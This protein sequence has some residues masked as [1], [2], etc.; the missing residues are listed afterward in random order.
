MID[1]SELLRLFFSDEQYA[2]GVIKDI[3]IPLD[4]LKEP[5]Y[6]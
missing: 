1:E 5:D 3:S 2:D 6:P 4:D